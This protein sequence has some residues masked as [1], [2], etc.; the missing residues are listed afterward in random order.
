MSAR[1][2]AVT[3]AICLAASPAPAQQPARDGRP[4]AKAGTAS[5]AGV[6]LSD[7]PEPRPLRRARVALSGAELPVGLAAV[8]AEDGTFAFDGLAAGPY[9]LGAGKEAYITMTYGAR[10]PGSR[11]APIVLADGQRQ[12]VTVKIP[13]GAVIAGTIV[14]PE[15]QPLPRAYVAAMKYRLDTSTGERRLV[16]SQSTYTD[17]RGAYRIYG[18]AAGRYVL[19]TQPRLLPVPADTD[20][21]LLSTAEIQQALAEVRNGS[22]ASAGVN[23]DAAAR[24]ESPRGVTYAPIYYPGTPVAAE[25]STLTVIHG[26]ERNG[27]D[28]Q[29]QYVPTSKIDGV[30]ISPASVPRGTLIW[31]YSADPSVS[32]G[33]ARLTGPDADGRFSFNGIPPGQYT[34]AV[35]PSPLGGMAGSPP[36]QTAT[37]GT[38]YWGFA[39]VTVQGEDVTGISLALQPGITISGRVVFEGSR[40]PTVDFSKLRV[41][42]PAMQMANSNMPMP[43]PS[44]QL[45][46]T[47]RFTIPDLIPG[48]YR[49]TRSNVPGIRTPV[50][51]WW[52]KSLTAGGQE[53]LDG[54]MDLRQSTSDVVVTFSERATELAVTV[55]DARGHPDPGCFIVVFGS[56]RASWFAN[57]RRI[58]AIAPDPSGRFTVRNL[59]PGE[60]LAVAAADLED[61]EW[62]DPE[63][64]QRL[65]ASAVK[66]RLAEGERKTQDLTIR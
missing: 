36:P 58:A 45:D 30:M 8:T 16:A 51:S 35:R 61:G 29:V 44:L 57:S 34:V 56:D 14:D 33:R 62:F 40:Q 39:S 12:T 13:R 55:T 65:A 5:I 19:Q 37:G 38:M 49:F 11:G 22:A 21:R 46:A 64:L 50:G 48:P 15:G 24:A 41:P 1:S 20:M 18:L 25:A 53:L 42:I 3:F 52:V 9:T 63:V 54:P 66:L 2:L 60:Y 43:I 28:I 59:P 10:R 32:S 27:L 4:L 23:S 31:L 7:E 17:D 26:E 6:V 47:G